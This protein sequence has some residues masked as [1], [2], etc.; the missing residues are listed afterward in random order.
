MNRR[1]KKWIKLK[2][3]IQNKSK[4]LH[5]LLLELKVKYPSL[6]K[7]YPKNNKKSSITCNSKDKI[8]IKSKDLKNQMN[9][10]KEKLINKL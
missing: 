2:V 6:R 7:K 10:F 5:K 1:L 8:W 3:K 4:N 9:N